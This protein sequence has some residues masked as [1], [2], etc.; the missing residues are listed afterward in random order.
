ME[1][2]KHMT[3]LDAIEYIEELKEFNSNGEMITP[4]N[5]SLGFDTFYQC[6]FE[7]AIRALK[8]R[9]RMDI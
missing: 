7:H 4:K 2:A 1:R 6:A 9:A 3:D 8:E 5:K